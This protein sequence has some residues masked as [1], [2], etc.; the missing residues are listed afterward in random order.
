MATENDI[1][2]WFAALSGVAQA[3]AGADL[4][5]AERAQA[6]MLIEIGIRIGESIVTDLNRIANAAE[7]E[8]RRQE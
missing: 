5:E 8:L 2:G 1:K 6:K 4:P 3:L 7:E